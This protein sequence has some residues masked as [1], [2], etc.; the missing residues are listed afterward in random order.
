MEG[1]SELHLKLSAVDNVLQPNRIQWCP[2]YKEY[3][4]L[5]Q[6]LVFVVLQQRIGTHCTIAGDVHER[7]VGRSRDKP[8]GQGDFKSIIFWTK[9]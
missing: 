7:V 1:P 2:S 5:V 8:T 3:V 9:E 6:I 4:S